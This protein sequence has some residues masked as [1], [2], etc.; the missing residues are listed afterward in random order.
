MI[1]APDQMTKLYRLVVVKT[2]TVLIRSGLQ[3]YAYG[4]IKKNIGPY[5]RKTHLNVELIP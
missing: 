5:L 1:S 2:I 3:T 4:N